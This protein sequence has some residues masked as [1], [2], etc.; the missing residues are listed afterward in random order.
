M[1]RDI[2][3]TITKLQNFRKERKIKSGTAEELRTIWDGKSLIVIC[4]LEKHNIYILLPANPWVAF[5]F[6]G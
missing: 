5:Q 2:Y 3:A 6:C 4:Y 1:E